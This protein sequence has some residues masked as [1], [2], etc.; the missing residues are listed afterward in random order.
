MSIV[1]TPGYVL[2]AKGD[3]AVPV[4]TAPKAFLW[5]YT[6]ALTQSLLVQNAYMVDSPGECVLTLPVN[7]NL[8]DT[9]KIIAKNT[10]RIII[11]QNAGQ[12][13]IL[14]YNT[15]TTVGISGSLTNTRKYDTIEITCISPSTLWLAQITGKW[16]PQ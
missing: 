14:D 5:T 10:N 8:G 1:F 4:Y 13:I 12:Q 15:A 3:G 11:A 9:I 2:V 6:T 16:N 7:A